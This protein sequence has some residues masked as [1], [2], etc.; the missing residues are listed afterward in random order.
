M[1]GLRWFFRIDPARE[2][3]AFGEEQRKKV[4]PLERINLVVENAGLDNLPLAKVPG[5]R[6]TGVVISR[7]RDARTGETHVATA[8]TTLH[9]GDVLLAVGTR[10]GLEQFTRII[11]RARDQDLAKSAGPV[12][13]RR[14]VVTRNAV[15]GKS[16]AE[17]GLGK[18]FG[19][20][21][22]RVNRG[23]LEMMAGPGLRLRFG[24]VLQV[25][26]DPGDLAAITPLLGDSTKRLGETQFIPLFVGIALGVLVGVIPIRVPGMSVPL[27]LGLA[28]GPLIVG[29]VLSRLGHVR[30]LV[31][32]MPTSANLAFR[33]LGITLF[34]AAVGLTAGEKFFS[35]VWSATGLLWLLC[36]LAI[37]LIPLLLVGAFARGVMKMNYTTL[38]GLIAG[39]TTDP[40]ALAFAGMMT[41]SDGPQ[42]AYA[43]VYPLTMLLR[44]LAA[45]G[46]ALALCR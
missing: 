43:T 10:E 17:I 44:V 30:N 2:A 1:L 39:S 42:V 45:Q 41:G 14:V 27:R 35:T 9:L 31:W 15:L 37:T 21:V 4:E 34:L 23:G 32:H 36:A 6:E 25:V 26:G 24:D 3:E 28:G 46:L 29:I 16:L 40:P 8:G 20:T 12:T 33:E 22:T 18:Q 19:V 5:R 11:G 38:S 13:S 7:V